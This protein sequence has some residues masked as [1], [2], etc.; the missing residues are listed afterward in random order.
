ME[1]TPL[2]PEDDAL[3]LWNRSASHDCMS[4]ALFREKFPE[5]DGVPT[6]GA[7]VAR[8]SGEAMGMVVSVLR[9]G[10]DAPRGY[11]KL[12]AVAPEH[13]RRGIGSQLLQ[14]AEELLAALGVEEIRIAESAPNYLTPGIDARCTDALAFFRRHG[15]ESTGKAINMLVDLVDNRPLEALIAQQPPTECRLARAATSDKDALLAFLAEHWPA[16]RSEASV[17]LANDP[18]TLH[19]AWRGEQLVGF[20]AFECNNRGTSW[21]G[22][23][24]VAPD[25]RKL[26]LGKL[27]LA[28]CLKDMAVMDFDQATIPW[29]GPPEFYTQTVGAKVSRE[30][31]RLSKRVT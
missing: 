20:S 7:L 5:D 8:Q 4:D 31:V 3:E 10:D 15:Y 16:W 2:T 11:I 24:G 23:M 19:L 13:R 28:Q 29:V 6:G 18:P 12:L 30:F 22:P 21:F 26:G 14:R 17:A 27:L 9:A 25:A 1:L